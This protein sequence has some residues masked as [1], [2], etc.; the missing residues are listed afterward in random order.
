LPSLIAYERN[1]PL[2][3]PV[4]AGH[5]TRVDIVLKPVRLFGITVTVIDDRGE[6]VPNA[7]V[8]VIAER[9]NWS[10]VSGLQTGTD[11]SLK[12]APVLPGPVRLLVKAAKDDRY[13]GGSATIDV[14][15]API[16]VTIPLVESATITGRVEFVGRVDPLHGGDGLHVYD[17][18]PDVN[19]GRSNTDPSGIVRADG[20][21]M[22]W[23]LGEQCLMLEGIP[24][25]WRLLDIAYNGDDYTRRPFLLE[26]AQHLSGVVIRVEPDDPAAERPTRAC[27][28]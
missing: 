16:E 26:S 5:R 22:V 19:L 13:L 4:R 15:D 28:R 23:A 20:E 1:T 14:A 11:G 10:L 12:I 27:R 24:S 3:A 25:G 21:F 17:R 7:N 8:H 9:Q 18:P 2:R 6:L